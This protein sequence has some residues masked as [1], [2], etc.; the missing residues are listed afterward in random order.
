MEAIFYM[1][2]TGYQRWRRL[3]VLPREQVECRR[4]WQTPKEFAPFIAVQGYFYRFCSDG[5]LDRIIH[6]LVS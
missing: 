1:L 2:A 3:T 4:R 6:V 5:T